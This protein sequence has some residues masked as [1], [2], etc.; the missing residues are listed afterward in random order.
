MRVRY[1][2]GTWPQPKVINAMDVLLTTNASGD[3][4]WTFPTAF[5]NTL[6][7]AQITPSGPGAVGPFVVKVWPTSSG[8]T[9]RTKVA[10]RVYDMA[11]AAVPS[12]TVA[13]NVTA[14]G[15]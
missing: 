7:G 10:F 2:A 12:F 9:D 8:F 6:V 1:E 13:V 15:Y 11:G 5:P 4:T 14:W 3:A